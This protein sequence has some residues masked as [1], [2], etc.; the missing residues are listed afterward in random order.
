MKSHEGYAAFVRQPIHNIRLYLLK[1]FD[2][3]AVQYES[4]SRFSHNPHEI[5]PLRFDGWAVA[6]A[7]VQVNIRPVAVWRNRESFV[8]LFLGMSFDTSA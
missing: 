2:Y 5:D 1:V 8:T 7:I 6:R 3:V 4:L